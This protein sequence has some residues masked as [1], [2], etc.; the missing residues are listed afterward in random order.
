MRLTCYHYTIGAG[1]FLAFSATSAGPLGALEQQEAE[2][3]GSASRKQGAP[4]RSADSA[5]WK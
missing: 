1:M 5:S 4:V 2:R 3:E